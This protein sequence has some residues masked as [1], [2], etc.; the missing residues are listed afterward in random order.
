[1]SALSEEE[2]MTV[3]SLPTLKRLDAAAQ[4]SSSG[5]SPDPID[6]IADGRL[7]CFGTKFLNS[8]LGFSRCI[9]WCGSMARPTSF[10][11][12]EAI[13]IKNYFAIASVVMLTLMTSMA[14]QA[15]AKEVVGSRHSSAEVGREVAAPP[16]SA[17]CMTDHGPSECDEPMWVYGSP[18]A[19]SRYKSAF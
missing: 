11:E 10:E 17:A 1:L 6:G 5:W 12:Q 13:V 14:N 15:I 3:P 19:V 8:N 16:W 7:V 4:E 2:N 18:V 9:Y